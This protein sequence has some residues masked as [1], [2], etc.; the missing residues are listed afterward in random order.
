MYDSDVAEFVYIV[1]NTSGIEELTQDGLIQLWPL[2]VR[3]VLNVT[4]GGKTIKSVVVAS[5]NGVQVAASNSCSA[6][7]TLDMNAVEA[8][9]YVVTIMTDDGACSRK[10]LKVE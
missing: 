3:N 4:A 8:G 7:V 2:P 10:I 5:L 9:I 6:M 1:D